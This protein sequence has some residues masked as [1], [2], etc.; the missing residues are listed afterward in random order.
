M[1]SAAPN[2]DRPTRRVVGVDVGGTKM[3]AVVVDPATGEVLDRRR[4]PTPRHDPVGLVR[5]L[6]DL[7]AESID[8]AGPAVAIGIGLPGLVGLDGVLR[9]GPNVPGV[10]DLDVV[11]PLSERFDLPVAVDNDAANAARA[12]LAWGRA[13]GKRHA[14]LVT[15]GTGIGGALIID[16]R[17]VRG[18]HG[19]AGEPGH[20]LID[21]N[22]HRCACGRRGCWETVSSGAGLVNLASELLD[23]GRG[24]RFVELAGGDRTAVRGEHVSEAFWEGD[25]DA[26]EVLDRFA[27]WVATGIGSLVSILDPEIVILGGGLSEITEQFIGEVRER[28]PALTMGGEHRPRVEIVRATFGPEAGAIGAGLAGLE[29]NGVPDRPG[30]TI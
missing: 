9:Y 4:R 15:Q 28:V 7:I 30:T 16:G 10:L 26:I 6:G 17:V 13:Q 21:T 2:E 22:G 27:S 8:A 20:M 25:S 19:F 3:L 29:A 14:V 12:E 24:R 11:G 5:D 18:A 1:P 23:E